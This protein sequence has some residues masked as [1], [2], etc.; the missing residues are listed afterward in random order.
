VATTL[1]ETL[2]TNGATPSGDFLR[3]IAAIDTSGNIAQLGADLVAVNGV[4]YPQL[5]VT[6]PFIDR[7][8]RIAARVSQFGFQITQDCPRA[9]GHVF[10]TTTLDTNFW[11][12]TAANGGT[13]VI[14]VPIMRL[15][16]NTTAN[17]SYILQSNRV[18][19]YM[20]PFSNRLLAHVRFG[21]T[22]VAN[23]VRRFGAYDANN[24]MGFV[25]NG[26]TLQVF[27]RNT[28]VDTVVSNGSFNGELTTITVDTNFHTF[29]VEYSAGTARFWYDRQLLHTMSVTTGAI[30][31]YLHLPF[32]IETVNSASSTTDASIYLR[33]SG[34][35]RY[36]PDAG[37]PTFFHTATADTLAVLKQGPCRLHSVQI[38]RSAASG[39][40]LTIY[41]SNGTAANVVAVISLNTNLGPQTFECDLQNGLTYTTSG[42]TIDVTL[43]YD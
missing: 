9:L 1:I 23:N 29:E 7:A 38:N 21:D 32:R 24:G 18:A 26:T 2:F 31:D 28:A 19:R 3:A 35:H 6:G 36:G 8:T 34:I 25:L 40:L 11:T 4:S 39:A 30:S 22:G 16:T 12:A 17:G 13:G 43:I 20:S 41:D 33:G 37:E 15:R 27:R 10:N 42:S 5:Q 14:T